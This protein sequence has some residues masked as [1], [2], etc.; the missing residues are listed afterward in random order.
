MNWQSED[1][2]FVAAAKNGDQQA[3]SELVKRHRRLIYSIAYK[4]TLCEEDS[5]DVTQDVYLKLVAKLHEYDG[6]GNFRAWLATITARTAIDFLRKAHHKEESVEPIILEE[7]L[8]QNNKQSQ[9]NPRDQFDRTF[10]KEKIELAMHHLSPQQRAILTLRLR[11]EMEP[12]E[13]G[14]RMGIAGKQVRTQLHRA[15]CKLKEVIQIK[16]STEGQNYNESQ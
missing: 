12:K 16:E 3:F 14:E 15:I 9:N 7:L 11:E 4:I 8:E 5:L 6:A 1:N 10:Q 13:I 2:Q